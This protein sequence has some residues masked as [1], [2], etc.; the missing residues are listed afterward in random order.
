MEESNTRYSKVAKQPNL[1][2]PISFP[3]S[4]GCLPRFLKSLGC[5]MLEL[6]YMLFDCLKIAAS[7][8]LFIWSPEIVP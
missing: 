7:G 3:L 4:L 2:I 8:Y 1:I 6:K 5:Q